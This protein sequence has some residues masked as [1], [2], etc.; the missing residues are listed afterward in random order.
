MKRIT[1]FIDEELDHEIHSLA[2]REG[3]PVAELVRDALGRYVEEKAR[4]RQPGLRF[5]A[6]GRSGQKRIAEHHEGFL[7]QDFHVAQSGSGEEFEALMKRLRHVNAG[8]AF[9]RDEMQ[10]TV[11]VFSVQIFVRPPYASQSAIANRR[12]PVINDSLVSQRRHGIHF[13]RAACG[14]VTSRERHGDQHER[15]HHKRERIGRLN[16]IEDARHQPR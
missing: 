9:S 5:P 8:R 4:S 16:A 15:N 3:V 7:W 2:S 12:L 1:V 6:A 14:N 10:G 11:K 13:G